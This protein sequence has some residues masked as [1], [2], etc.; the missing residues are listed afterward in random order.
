MKQV[1][2]ANGG[3]VNVLGKLNI[4]TKTGDGIFAQTVHVLDKLHHSLI[5]G[6][7]FMK[8]KKAFINFVQSTLEIRDNPKVVIGSV[9]VNAGLVR[10]KQKITIAPH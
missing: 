2:T 3:Q 6:I 1:I 10:T 4:N 5:L 8:T 7:D 9:T